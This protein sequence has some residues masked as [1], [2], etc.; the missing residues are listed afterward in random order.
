MLAA[1]ASVALYIHFPYCLSICPYCD[2]DRQVN[3]RE[4]ADAYL[5]AVRAEMRGYQERRLPVH[6]IFFGGGTPSLMSTA[7]VAGLMEEAATSFELLP[8]AEVTLESNPG[9]AN[10]ARMR[11]LRNV[12]VTRLSFGVQS[13]DDATLKALG[14]RHSAEEARAAVRSAR[15]A[16]FSVSFDLMYALPGQSLEHWSET[17]EDAMALAPDHLSCY[18]LTVDERV[19]MGRDVAR[20]RLTLPD[21]DL[22]ADMYEHARRRLREQGYRQ[23]E[24]SNWARPGHESR[25]NLTYWRDG[26]WVGVGAGAAS[27]LD[28]RR[29]KNAPVVERYVRALSRGRPAPRS[30]D[31]LPDRATARHDFLALGLRLREGV[32]GTEYRRRFGEELPDALGGSGRELLD[33]GILTWDGSRL[34]LDGDH[35][36]VVN[37]VL[38]RLDESNGG[39]VRRPSR[40]AVD[41]ELAQLS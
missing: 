13:L 29:W 9:D 5:A 16:G 21:D 15:A 11:E 17:L 8:D 25:H 30:E 19:P 23:Y 34:Q 4:K 35:Q 37:E 32:S 31:E 1:P 27:S 20:G 41:Q 12:G 36:M 38:L 7:Q 18:L 40:P 33:A 26:R 28:G 22:A 10:L 6:S 3:G 39:G 14:R 24:I 2:F